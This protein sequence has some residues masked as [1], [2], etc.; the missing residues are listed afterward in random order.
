MNF[1]QFVMSNIAVWNQLLVE[2]QMVFNVF[3]LTLLPLIYYSGQIFDQNNILTVLP[4]LQPQTFFK[5]AYSLSKLLDW[6]HLLRIVPFPTWLLIVTFPF[7]R[8]TCLARGTKSY[9][10]TLRY[11]SSR[12]SFVSPKCLLNC[13]ICVWRSGIRGRMD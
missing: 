6:I 4:L 13:H 5:L 2:P 10:N 7:C 8:A 11:N 12:K 9:A 3:Y 1:C